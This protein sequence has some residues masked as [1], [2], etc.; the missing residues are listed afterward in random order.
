MVE[1]FWS[2]W[3]G[4]IQSM[5]LNPR[6]AEVVEQSPQAGRVVLAIAILGGIGLLL[7]Q[8][9]IL[10]V[11]QVRPGRFVLSLLVNGVV[12][13]AGLAI[14]GLAIWAIGSWIFPT[15]PRLALVMT[16]IGLSAAPY[17][18]G[19]FV[20]IPY[21]GEFAYR[22]LSV[23]SAVIATGATAY[24]FR[25]SW[26][27]AFLV[28]GSSWLLIW[29]L[30]NTLGRPLLGLRSRVMQAV[31]GTRMDASVGDILTQFAAPGRDGEP[32]EGGQP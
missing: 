22:V 23:W 6:V 3:Q 4:V 12:F 2:V 10:F 8:S 1:F 27:P 18:F 29:A 17:V 30:S 20:L 7:G 24:S 16:L 21:F 19:F 26:W 25:V 32:K 15:Q 28:V 5:A 13:A 31:T 11:N 14:W 9:V